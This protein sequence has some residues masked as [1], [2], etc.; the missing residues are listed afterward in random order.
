MPRK[1]DPEIVKAE[2]E[3]GLAPLKTY[4]TKAVQKERVEKAKEK[5]QKA[6]EVAIVAD[7][8]AGDLALK[9]EALHGLT[10]RQIQI[11][12]LSLRGFPQTLIAQVLSISQPL[13]SRELSRVKQHIRE[14]GDVV[15]QSEVVGRSLT[16]YDDVQTKAYDLYHTN[17]GD[18]GTQTKALQLIL[19]AE[20][21]RM[22]LLMDL[23]LVERAAQEVNHNM[24]QPSKFV[25]AWSEGQV[26][27]AARALLTAALTPLEEP[28]P[29]EEEEEY[30]E[31]EIIS[32]D[33]DE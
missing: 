31:G 16:V 25:K 24:V 22:K 27:T 28:R 30:I 8:A 4:R 3:L 32:T 1:R 11:L 13:V 7:K 9:E 21:D 15:D 26:Q 29:P 10:E 33:D 5:A 6:T 14:R 19:Q 20:K 12:K 18:A 17:L 23:G 2:E